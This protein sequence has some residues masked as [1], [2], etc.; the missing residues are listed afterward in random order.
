MCAA[1]G[2]TIKNKQPLQQM[3]QDRILSPLPVEKGMLVYLVLCFAGS[4]SIVICARAA[5]TPYL[6][7]LIYSFLFV[8]RHLTVYHQTFP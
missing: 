8:Y 3:R 1:C 2:G 6:L 5:R 4:A 7:F